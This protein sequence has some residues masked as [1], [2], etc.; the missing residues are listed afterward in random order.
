MVLEI[1]VD[2]L[3]SA[4]AA[5]KGGADRVELC[6]NLLEGGTTPSAG[7]IRAV[8]SKIAIGLWV[9]IRPRGGDFFYSEAEFEVMC[10]DIEAALEY[11][12]N[13]IVLGLL[14]ANGQVDVRRTRSLI[15]MAAPM[16]VTFHRAIDKSSNLIESV[17]Q[18][19]EAGADGILTSG[20]MQMAHQGAAQIA[21]MVQAAEGQVRMMVC[22]GIRPG[23]V[24]EIVRKTGADDV[25][26][27]LRSR[28][29]SQAAFRKEAL[30]LGAFPDQEYARYI[31][32]SEDVQALRQAIEGIGVQSV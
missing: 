27:G 30:S 32:F 16:Y 29:E 22:G 14:T 28:V 17:E 18:V 7:L 24:S 25:H 1:C 21:A 12:A 8:R 6:S 11:G 5:E 3:E 15:E 23:N 20:G 10:H 26:S 19:I 9:M 31:V 4:I 2:S 13:G